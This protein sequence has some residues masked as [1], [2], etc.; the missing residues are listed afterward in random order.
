MF[1]ARYFVHSFL[2]MLQIE[3]I[4]GKFILFQSG[5]AN[6]SDM[7]SIAGECL[8]ETAKSVIYLE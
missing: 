4:C 1:L 5:A 7:T 2:P 3:C 6:V 8:Q